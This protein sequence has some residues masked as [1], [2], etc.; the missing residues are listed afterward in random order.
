MLLLPVRDTVSERREQIV[1]RRKLHR[2]GS[3]QNPPN[4]F[5][6]KWTKAKLS[7]RRSREGPPKWALS[8][9]STKRAYAVV[10]ERTAMSERRSRF[11]SFQTTR[12]R[13]SCAYE[14]PNAGLADDHHRPA[15]FGHDLP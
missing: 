9:S 8:L 4:V 3:R 15:G 5:P 7:P 11:S 1:S 13:R 2:E 6:V 10:S 12:L 14:I